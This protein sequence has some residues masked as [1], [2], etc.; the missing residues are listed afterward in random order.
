MTRAT[1]DRVCWRVTQRY[2][3]WKLSPNIGVTPPKSFRVFNAIANFDHTATVS[4]EYELTAPRTAYL[5][6]GTRNFPRRNLT[7]LVL[8]CFF[9]VALLL[10]VAFGAHYAGSAW[11]RLLKRRT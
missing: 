2:I 8:V 11:K 4:V 9:Y 5:L 6:G 3:A 1:S 10:G 7:G